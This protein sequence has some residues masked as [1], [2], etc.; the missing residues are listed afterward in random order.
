MCPITSLV[1][2]PPMY[3]SELIDQTTSCWKEDVVRAVFVPIDAE[4]ILKIPLCTRK[5]DNFWA[6]SKEPRGNFTIR[7]AYKM[8]QQTKMSRESWLEERR[9]NS[10]DG[11][12]NNG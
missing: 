10:N 3:V 5:V 12:D 9:G 11:A 1:A 2:Q 4:E 8:I 6:G 7:S